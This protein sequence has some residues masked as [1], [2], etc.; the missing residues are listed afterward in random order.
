M[1]S[2]HHFSLFN[3]NVLYAC[4]KLFAMNFIYLQDMVVTQLGLSLG[5]LLSSLSHG[6]NTARKG[7][8]VVVS[9][10]SVSFY[11]RGNPRK[12]LKVSDVW[13]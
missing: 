9:S 4:D 7:A 13:R 2:Y 12:K 8:F 3:F 5:L 11:E 10:A 1:K 6:G